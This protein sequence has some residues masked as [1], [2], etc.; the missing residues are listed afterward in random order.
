MPMAGGDKK[1]RERKSLSA[2][3]IMK[4]VNLS[5]IYCLG[6][7]TRQTALEL[8]PQD[9]IVCALLELQTS[10]GGLGEKEMPG[11]QLAHN[12]FQTKLGAGFRISQT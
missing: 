2:K 6:G 10:R 1:K 5:E 3:D 9:S 8:S 11:C 7:Q 4:S 12:T